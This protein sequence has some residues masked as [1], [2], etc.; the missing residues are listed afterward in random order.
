MATIVTRAGKGEPLTHAEVDANFTNLN[1]DKLESGSTVASLDINGGTIDGT[2]IGGTTAAAISGTTG[3]FSGDVTLPSINGGPLAGFRNAIINGNFGVNQRGFSGTVTL[4]AG[5][6]GHDRWKAG[7][8]GCTYT[9]ATSANVTTLT[10]TAGSLVQVIE[11]ANLFSGT[12]TLS[13]TGTAQGKIGAGSFGASGITGSVTG[14]TDLSIEFNTGTVAQV[15]L[16]A[17]SVATPFERRP[18][19]TELAL[20]QRYYERVGVVSSV[21]GAFLN[22]TSFM[23]QKRVQPSLSVFAGGLGGGSFASPDYGTLT[24]IIQT[25]NSAGAINAGIAADAEL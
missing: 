11:G 14:G 12:Y 19:G 5:V 4:A 21:S 16:E 6:Y 3:A 17:G 10:I 8:S 13:F 23:V 2:V 15:Q 1:A 25:V 24:S 7:A 9:F 18:V 20:C 22:A